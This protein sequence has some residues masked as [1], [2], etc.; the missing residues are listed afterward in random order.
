MPYDPKY[1]TLRFYWFID[2]IID[3]IIILLF[4]NISEFGLGQH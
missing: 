4:L 2:V 1:L 3:N